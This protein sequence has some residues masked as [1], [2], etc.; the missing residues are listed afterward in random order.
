M[1]YRCYAVYIREDNAW[2]YHF[3]FVNKEAA[4]HY[5]AHYHKGAAIV[6][7]TNLSGYDIPET[8]P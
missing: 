1:K 3:N 6:L 7:G 4:K 5:A 2:H 8:L